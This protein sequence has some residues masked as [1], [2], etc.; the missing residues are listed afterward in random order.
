MFI[1]LQDTIMNAEQ[2]RMLEKREGVVCSE[3]KLSYGIEV[4]FSTNNHSGLFWYET[5]FKRNKEYERIKK[6]L[7]WR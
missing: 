2:I 3:N 6:A 1:E 4:I 5:K 7:I